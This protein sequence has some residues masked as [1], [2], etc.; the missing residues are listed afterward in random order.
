M[1]DFAGKVA[2]IT[3]AGRGIGRGIALRCAKEGMKVVLAGFGMEPITRTAA[4]LQALGAET[5]IV[6][7]D[8]SQLADVENLAEKSY[9]AFG[10]VD[11]LVNNA[12]VA[13]PAS[14]L[15]S[16]LDD[17][18]WVMGV[19]FYGVLYGVRVFIPRMMKQDTTS[20]VV[21]VSSLSGIE[22]GGGAYG[23]TKHG[24]VVLTEALYNDLAKTAPNVNVSVYCPGWVSTEF[25]G[26]ERSRPERFKGDATLPSDEQR[27]KW[28]EAL[29]GGYSIEKSA[30]ILFDGLQNSKLY[31]GPKGFQEQL[32]EF[33]GE[34]RERTENILNEVNPEKPS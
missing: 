21:N 15:E 13:V 26:V 34:V 16:T 22:Y 4:D 7:T 20:H 2:V 11:L 9:Q 3:G 1:N 6:Q 29:S 18:N 5:L 23:V 19:N 31:I 32:P 14:V 17:W 27:M 25:D 24:V 12:G 10:A 28:R 33:A 8:V 30:D